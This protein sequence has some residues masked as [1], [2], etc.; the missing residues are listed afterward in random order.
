VIASVQT[1]RRRLAA[2]IAWIYLLTRIIAGVVISSVR[3][4]DALTGLA[5]LI[6]A[7]DRRAKLSGAADREGRAFVRVLQIIQVSVLMGKLLA[8]GWQ[9]VGLVLIVL[10]EVCVLWEPVAG[11]MFVLPRI[12]VVVLEPG[13]R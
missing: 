13:R 6:L 2:Q 10:R 3:Q 9:L 12:I 8:L 7:G 1:R 5:R 4:G 11:R